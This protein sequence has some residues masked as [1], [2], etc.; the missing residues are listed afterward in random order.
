MYIFVCVYLCVCMR[1]Y[2]YI[3]IF[4]CIDMCVCVCVYKFVCVCIDMRVCVLIPVCVCVCSWGSGLRLL[5]GVL[6]EEAVV[7]RDPGS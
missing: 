2:L 5:H 3:S 1:V 7:Q 6:H 4:V